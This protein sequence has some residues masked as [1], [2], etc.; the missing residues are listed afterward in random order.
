MT[1]CVAA[2][3]LLVVGGG[4]IGLAS[5]REAAHRG[6]RVT[7]FDR[8]VP[9]RGSTWAAA[10]MLSPLSEAGDSGPFLRFG[11]DSLAMYRK[12]AQS[13]VAET[14][15]TFGFRKGE[16]LHLAASDAESR[17]LEDRRSRA[18][19]SGISVEWLTAEMLRTREPTLGP[20]FLAG[21]LIHDDYRL[22]NRRLVEALIEGCERAGVEVHSE[23]PVESIRIEGGRAVG[24]TLG[25]GKRLDGGAVLVAAGAWSRSLQGLP[26]PIG[27]K[28]IRGQMLSL[29]P[30]GPISDRVLESESVYLVPRASGQL[31][32]GATVEEVGFADA[33]TVGGIHGLL[34]AAIRMVP[35]L[36]AAP[37]QDTWS[38]LRPGTDDGE[39]IIGAD[40]DVDA[41][42]YATG[43]FRNGIL[44][45]PITARVISDL[46]SGHDLPPIPIEFAPGRHALGAPD[47]EIS[48]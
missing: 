36:R 22:D 10:G 38:G 32:V 17:I 6:L 39:P 45:A 46:I 9:G 35:D 23:T 8:G 12:W 14:N 3:D 19:K 41:L 5:A 48:R 16:K 28:P 31:L 24:V 44:L 42:F 43:H 18:T 40:P 25:G 37:I 1:E 13:L 2:P 20:S 7:I 15:L 30:E 27:V 4:V 29:A 26:R 33:V 21:L 47:R 34:D 11:L